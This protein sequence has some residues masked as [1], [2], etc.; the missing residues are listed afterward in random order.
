MA[1]NQGCES[2]EIPL[3]RDISAIIITSAL[4]LFTRAAESAL[5]RIFVQQPPTTP[6]RID[7][8]LQTACTHINVAV[9][10]DAL[11]AIVHASAHKWGLLG[12]LL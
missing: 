2:N 7:F 6:N 10:T 8:P 4:Y 11:P 9:R 1:L 5:S 3:L 12:T